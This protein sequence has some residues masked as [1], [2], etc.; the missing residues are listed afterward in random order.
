MTN[1]RSLIAMVHIGKARL[2]MDDATYRAWL[3]KHTGKRSSTDLTDR[4][5]AGLVKVLR[6]QGALEEAPAKAKVIA[7]RGGNRPTAAQWQTAKGFARKI[8][9]EGGLDGEAFAAFVKHVAKV[10]NPRFLTKASMADVLIGLEK[11]QQQRTQKAV[12]SASQAEGSAD[13]AA[14]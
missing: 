11:W 6:D 10:D 12:K 3:E 14:R 2:G 7:G 5:I 4:D 8:G 9:L 13:D 1:R